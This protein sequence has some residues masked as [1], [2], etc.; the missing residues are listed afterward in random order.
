MAVRRSVLGDEHVDRSIA[1]TT[2][3]NREF[4][5]MITRFAWGTVWTRPAVD[6]RTRRMMVLTAMASL[7]RW[8]EFRMHVRA[9]LAHE[10]EPC[11]LKEVL[12]QVGIYAGV[13]VANTG[14]HIAAE[15]LEAE[16]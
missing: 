4:Q 10:L 12:L 9:G 2:A 8:E 16:G 13:P 14:F 3:F 5:Q 15:E 1:H 11:D 7:G 6:H